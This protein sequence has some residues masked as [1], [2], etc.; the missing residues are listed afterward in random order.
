[1]LQLRETPRLTTDYWL[2]FSTESNDIGKIIGYSDVALY[3]HTES[4]PVYI[5]Q[6]LSGKE[7]RRQYFN[8]VGAELRIGVP[9]PQQQLDYALA[10]M[11]K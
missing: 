6:Y 8:V 5:L 11:K 7:L 3:M 4:I 9:T 1:M 10:V 2:W